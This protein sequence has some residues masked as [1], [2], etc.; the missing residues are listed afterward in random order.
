MIYF[1]EKQY[2][3]DLA[4]YISNQSFAV[5]TVCQGKPKAIFEF[6]IPIDLFKYPNE[7]VP[8]WV[9]WFRHN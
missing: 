8:I 1:V 7:V 3:W 2:G 5:K 9:Q 6:Q 4:F